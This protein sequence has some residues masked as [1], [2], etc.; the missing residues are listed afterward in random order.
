MSFMY[1]DHRKVELCYRG[2]FVGLEKWWHDMCTRRF[3]GWWRSE[4]GVEEMLA[5]A[6][7][8]ENSV[9]IGSILEPKEDRRRYA[10]ASAYFNAAWILVIC[11]MCPNFGTKSFE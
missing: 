4:V 5:F 10:A 3:E 11:N 8:Q 9:S 1:E 6:L 2:H 7:G